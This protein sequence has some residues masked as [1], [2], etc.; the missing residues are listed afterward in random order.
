MRL[1]ASLALVDT[2]YF[3]LHHSDLRCLML[4]IL[5]VL[6]NLCK[7]IKYLFWCVCDGE[8]CDSGM[9]LK[10]IKYSSGCQK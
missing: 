2:S 5:L 6:R 4:H 10:I 7:H 9:M 3:A 8:G 1:R